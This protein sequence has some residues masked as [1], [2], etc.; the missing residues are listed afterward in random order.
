MH[1]L[2]DFIANLDPRSV[3]GRGRASR[4]AMRAYAEEIE[5][6]S[7]GFAADLLDYVRRIDEAQALRTLGV[8]E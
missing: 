1:M 5:A 7:P 4:A 6:T 2:A 3:G 8:T